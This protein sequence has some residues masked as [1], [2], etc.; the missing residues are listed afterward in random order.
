MS[1]ARFIADQRTKYRVP[2]TVTCVMLGVS[3]SW[4]YK[5]VRRKPTPTGR[6][7]QR[8]RRRGQGRVRGVE[9]HH[10]S[11]RIHADLARPAG[12]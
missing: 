4:F 11:P 10:G 1:V 8:A 7:P 2:H 6:P 9:A 12:R 5:W 3:V